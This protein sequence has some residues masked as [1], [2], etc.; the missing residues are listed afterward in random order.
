MPAFLREDFENFCR[1]A[2]ADFTEHQRQVFCVFSGNGVAGL[3]RYLNTHKEF[4]EYHERDDR[5]MRAATMPTGATGVIPQANG[6]IDGFDDA[7]AVEDDDMGDGSEIAL[8]N[9]N[10]EGQA[11]VG[12]TNMVPPPPP[13]APVYPHQ[14]G[15]NDTP[16]PAVVVDDQQQSGDVTMDTPTLP[17]LAHPQISLDQGIVPPFS[18]QNQHPASL[19]GGGATTA[20]SAGPSTA[21]IRNPSADEQNQIR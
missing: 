14:M 3:R 9:G 17:H 11:A 10:D 18:V 7:D 2:P 4:S 21:S 12:A 15:A 19:A 13:P 6:D 20:A 5:R 16:F 1:D 8:D